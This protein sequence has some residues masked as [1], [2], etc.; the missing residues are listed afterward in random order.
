[1]L[2]LEAMR[3]RAAAL[4]RGEGRRG[5]RT[6]AGEG[7]RNDKGFMHGYLLRGLLRQPRVL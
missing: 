5:Q 2:L 4:L 7:K 1:L 6:E 3:E